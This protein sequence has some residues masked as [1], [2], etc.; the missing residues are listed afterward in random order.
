MRKIATFA[1]VA[2]LALAVAAPAFATGADGMGR[3]FG[4]D[5]STEARAMGGFTGMMNPGVE[6][7]GFSG[8]T[9]DH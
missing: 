9:M 5:H 8:W 3:A 6:H 7:R 4:A 2:V 1:V